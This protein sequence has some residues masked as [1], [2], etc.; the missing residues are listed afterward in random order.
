MGNSVSVSAEWLAQFEITETQ[1]R[2]IAK[3]QLGR[4]LE[5]IRGSIDES[6]AKWRSRLDAIDR[7][8][9]NEQTAV[10]PGAVSALVDLIKDLPGAIGA[11]LSRDER[12]VARAR[13]TLTELEARLKT[14]GID[15]DG[16]LGSFA[17]R[18]ASLRAKRDAEH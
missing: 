11:S 9:V 13:E 15:L 3:D 4:A 5:E 6:L 18:V 10:T 2:R 14:S 16:H 12:Q 7:T 17:D 8:P 1:A